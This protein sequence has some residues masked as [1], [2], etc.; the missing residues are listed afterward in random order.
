MPITKRRGLLDRTAG[1]QRDAWLCFIATEG[2]RDEPDYFYHLQ[3]SDFIDGRKV[4]IEIIPSGT[5]SAPEYIIEALEKIATKNELK[6]I[7]Q[8]WYMSD[9]DHNAS[10]NHIKNFKRALTDCDKKKYFVAISNPCFQVWLLLHFVDPAELSDMKDGTQLK[11]MLRQVGGYTKEFHLKC[12]SILDGNVELAIKRAE[13]LS[14]DADS[15]KWPSTPGTQVH[16]LVRQLPRAPR[17]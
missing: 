16:L 2:D 3:N 9:V 17:V 13:Q 6:P 7:D 8:L 12:G 1:R 10:P 11:E 4:Q 15:D 5:K 14:P